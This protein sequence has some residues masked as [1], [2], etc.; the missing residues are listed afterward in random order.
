MK[1][2]DHLMAFLYA[3]NEAWN[4]KLEQENEEGK[5]ISKYRNTGV[6]MASLL[7]SAVYAEF[8]KMQVHAADGLPI[9]ENEKG[10][11]IVDYA[12]EDEV[13]IKINVHLK[14]MCWLSRPKKMEF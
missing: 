13:S 11:E 5:V 9:E 1:N 6:K 2:I 7:R 3:F 4:N 12:Y 10:W 8:G 14:G